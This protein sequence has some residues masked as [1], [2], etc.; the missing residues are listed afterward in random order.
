MLL[1]EVDMGVW[2]SSSKMVQWLGEVADHEATIRDEEKA[3]E[4]KDWCKWMQK[5]SININQETDLNKIA[6]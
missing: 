1:L 3:T 2:T 4:E 5:V 6:Y